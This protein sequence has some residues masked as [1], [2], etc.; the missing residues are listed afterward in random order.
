MSR[1]LL[2]NVFEMTVDAAAKAIVDRLQKHTTTCYCWVLPSGRI[3]IRE[4]NYK[5]YPLPDMK[6]LAGAYNRHARVENVENDLIARMHEIT[7]RRA[8]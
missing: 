5:R 8:A 2:G 3:V 4:Q 6:F 1:K 7:R